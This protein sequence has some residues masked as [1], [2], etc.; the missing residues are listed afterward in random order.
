MF[1]CTQCICGSCV[2]RVGPRVRFQHAV[3][4]APLLL[5]RFGLV[6]FAS[7]F[8]GGIDRLLVRVRHL[9]LPSI[10][11]DRLRVCWSLNV[12][13]G[14]AVRKYHDRCRFVT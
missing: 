4:E 7:A 6:A 14:Y 5:V 10:D 13:N 3:S 9:P 2:P 11:R 1:L 8:V 12:T